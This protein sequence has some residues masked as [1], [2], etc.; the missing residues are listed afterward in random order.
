MRASCS[1]SGPNRPGPIRPQS[2]LL[3]RSDVLR[4]PGHKHRVERNLL[5][6]LKILNINYSH[7]WRTCCIPRPKY[8]CRNPT[9]I[10]TRHRTIGLSQ[11]GTGSRSNAVLNNVGSGSPPPVPCKPRVVYII[12]THGRLHSPCQSHVAHWPLT[13]SCMPVRLESCKFSD[14]SAPTG[15]EP[16]TRPVLLTCNMGRNICVSCWNYVVALCK[17]VGMTKF[18]FPFLRGGICFILSLLTNSNPE[19]VNDSPAVS[20]VV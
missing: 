12:Q 6:S 11:T 3:G 9:V 5:R 10:H 16:A 20:P 8:G 7:G 14:G 2:P 4:E 18:I 17:N 15:C 13:I 19:R 1:A